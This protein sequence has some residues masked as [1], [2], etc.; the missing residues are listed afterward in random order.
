MIPPLRCI[1]L[2][3]ACLCLI[4]VAPRAIAEDQ[5]P[6]ADSPP[7]HET[8]LE[9]AELVGKG[10]LTVYRKGDN[11]ILGIPAN[12]FEKPFLWYTEGVRMPG[13]RPRTL[14]VGSLLAQFERRAG[15]VL[16]RDLTSRART[17]SGFPG[18]ATRYTDDGGSDI[19]PIDVA[20]NKLALG[21]VISSAEV[22][23]ETPD[24]TVLVDLTKPFS[25]DI[26][27]AS[28]RVFFI[29]TNLIPS[30]VD[31]GGTYLD[32]VKV[33]GDNLHVRAHI[34]LLVQNP[35]QPAAPAVPYSF[36]LGHSLVR[37]PDEPMK[38]R[39]FDPRVGFFETQFTVYEA[40]SGTT[41]ERHGAITRFRLEK[42]N[43]EAA[44]SD[45][46]E[47]ITFYIGPGVPDR[48]RPYVKAG[49][50]LWQ[51]AL[52]AAGFSNAIRAV[53]A[54]SPEEDPDFSVEDVSKSMIRWLTQPEVNAMG[55]RVT[56]PRSGETLSS[57]V[58]IWPA[59]IES[60]SHYYFAIYS[61]L[62]PAAARLPLPLER[63]GEIL[64]YGV[65]HEVGHALGLRHNHMASTAYS[66]KQ[67][68]D[69]DF[70]NR[71][72][73]SSSI[74]GYGR[75]NQVAQPGDGITHFIPG[76]GPYD[77]AAIQWGY[78]DFGTDPNSEQQALDAFAQRFVEQRELYWGADETARELE[79]FSLD[80]RVQKENIGAERIEA[81][82][83]GISNILRTLKNLDAATAGDDAL[84]KAVYY[85]LLKR[86]M[87]FLKSVTRLVGGTMRRYRDSEGPPLRYVPAEEQRRAVI[88]LLGEGAR[89]LEPYQ[90]PQLIERVAPLGGYRFIEQKQAELVGAVLDHQ[91][92]LAAIH[93][94]AVLESQ[95]AR[96]K[97]AYSPV[98]L[99]RDVG[100]SIWGDLAR[101]P[102]WKRALQRAHIAETRALLEAWATAG[103]EEDAAR[104]AAMAMGLSEPFAGIV[105]E[106][107]DDTIY[108]AWVRE[109]LPFLRDRLNVAARDA[110]ND[111]DRLH[112]QEMAVQMERLIVMSR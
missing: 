57:H 38:L 79:L 45:P 83:L 100:K 16:V 87:G 77:Y 56:D 97:K 98:D 78:G 61:T 89:S 60:F 26:S 69:A 40:E 32:S 96:D 3:F 10:A 58:L 18:Q 86:H 44:V 99:G 101:A 33:F 35:K 9:G 19:P 48:W 102:F 107:G 8:L 24:G 106:T 20:L 59:F 81:T 21:A 47:P 67:L 25:G 13:D 64:K 14:E 103:A 46:V 108:A 4:L 53:D 50:E 62:D 29:N 88:Y 80:P 36:V 91:D 90:N 65:A 17:V 52:E 63:R 11:Y 51:P 49:V 70:A 42:A 34:T 111:S 75:W 84:F 22:A 71:H 12:A 23:A 85:E 37:L 1:R 2:I 39:R 94:I 66:V 54:P 104:Q 68:R 27:S 93:K 110:S 30:G 109:N 82:R 31:P 74:M 5:S 72:G 105:A 55:P 28:A 76:L 7:A 15:R 43:P 73:A 92:H 112:F 41:F 95:S 6:S